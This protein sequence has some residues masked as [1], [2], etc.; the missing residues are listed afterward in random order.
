MLDV[1]SRVLIANQNRCSARSRVEI[2]V[3]PVH[4]S[5]GSSKWREGR[6]LGSRP[7]QAGLI[8]DSK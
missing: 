7:R 1:L 5:H 8:I 3:Q 6:K 4:C 2:V